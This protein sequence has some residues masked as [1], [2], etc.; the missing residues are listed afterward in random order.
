MQADRRKDR[1]ESVWI[2]KKKRV[3]GKG[4]E[5]ESGKEKGKKEKGRLKIVRKGKETR[6]RADTRDEPLNLSYI[7]PLLAAINGEVLA[8][9]QPSCIG[10]RC[11]LDKTLGQDLTDLLC[12]IGRSC[13]NQRVHQVMT[14]END[15]NTDKTNNFQ[16]HSSAQALCHVTNNLLMIACRSFH[17]IYS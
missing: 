3:G 2:K 5:R 15:I 9:Y 14:T 7:T 10:H 12:D 6:K 13:P 11:D 16:Q 4:R 8:A 1:T 17:D